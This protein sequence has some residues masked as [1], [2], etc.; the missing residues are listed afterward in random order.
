[1]A[2]AFFAPSSLPRVTRC[3]GSLLLTY[4]M[5]DTQTVF[6]AE[7][8]AAHHIADLALRGK[9]HVERY[10]GCKIAVSKTGECVFVHEGNE[11]QLALDAV[12]GNQM[13]FEVDDE[14][15]NAVQAYVDW[16][17]DLPGEHYPECK[18][19]ISRWTP[20]RDATDDPFV[21]QEAF[22]PQR[23]TSD[24]AACM[25]FRLVITDLKYGKGEQVFAE[26][27]EQ[28][29][30]YALGFI[31]E[32]DWLYDFQEIEIRICQPRLDHYDTWTCT[33]AEL[34][35]IG[36]YI[37]QQCTT[38]LQPDAPLVPG[39]KQ[40][41]FCKASGRCRA[42]SEWLSS[43]RALAFDD[44][45]NTQFAVPDVRLLTD[46]EL[47]EAWR[48]HQL[49]KARFDAI[50]REI[51]GGLKNGCTFPGL[52]IVEAKSHRKWKDPKK[53]VETLV[54]DYNI[55]LDKIVG[56]DIISPSA[57]EKLLKKAD[58]AVVAELAYKPRGG[59]CIADAND[60]RPL[61]TEVQQQQVD[62]VFDDLDTDPFA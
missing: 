33:R 40:C 20:K 41:K 1:M 22:T 14:M 6:A 11:K 28:A 45:D 55:P 29:V 13:I 17:N 42:Q 24:H 38:A 37:L 54:F 10:A 16:C 58:R 12:F 18:V 9:H 53:V 60:K 36:R 15:V 47:V 25:P 3:P 50:E 48:A 61:Y 31:E 52:K 27:N 35:E 30:A 8:T 62:S 26:R 21:P 2:H 23:G 51:V 4:G 44:L 59:P 56:E 46:E 19:D 5:P 34:E 39:E 7:G 57:A 49:Y 32:W 43:M